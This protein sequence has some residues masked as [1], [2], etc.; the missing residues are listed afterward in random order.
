[1]KKSAV[2][3]SYYALLD[4]EETQVFRSLCQEQNALLE[5]AEDAGALQRSKEWKALE[6]KREAE[7]RRLH[8]AFPMNPVVMDWYADICTDLVEVRNLK[9]MARAL[10]AH[11]DPMRDLLAEEIEGLSVD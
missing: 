11:D 1:M 9:S 5:A 4:S 6:K 2:R 3:P 7:I 8:D 10:L